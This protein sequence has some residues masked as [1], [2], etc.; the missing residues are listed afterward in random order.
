MQVL[1]RESN[2]VAEDKNPA[3]IQ[4]LRNEVRASSRSR[5][6]LRIDNSDRRP[7]VAALP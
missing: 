7:S 5:L 4:R 1:M 3:E 2:E 6:S